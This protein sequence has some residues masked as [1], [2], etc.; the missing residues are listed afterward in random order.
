MP[1]IAL[2][3]HVPS[4]PSMAEADV[5]PPPAVEA[6]TEMCLLC[7]DV[8]LLKLQ[9]RS[10]GIYNNDISSFPLLTDDCYQSVECPLFVTWEIRRRD[11]NSQYEL[12]GCIGSLSP[13]PLKSAVTKYAIVAGF[14]DRR[15]EAL[16]P[17][18]VAH[19][20]VGVSLLVHYEPCRDVFDWTV[21]VHGIMI[22]WRDGS[23]AD[24][25]NYSATYLPEVAPQ[26]RWNVQQAV[27]SLI[28]KAGY[29]KVIS[30]ELLQSIACTRYQSSKSQLDFA[31]YLS[32]RDLD[33]QTLAWM[34]SV[35][36]HRG[37]QNCSVI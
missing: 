28:R 16:T 24:A 30:A 15:F 23:S 7:F 17:P 2:I 13:L 4:T 35:N 1:L 20:R 29:T 8:M 9:Q 36:N 5:T 19:L 32:N 26:Q 18:E 34:G 25:Y 12:R 27:E 21:G 37:G 31:T 10:Q 33:P 3:L 14:K 11:N 22:S 6:T